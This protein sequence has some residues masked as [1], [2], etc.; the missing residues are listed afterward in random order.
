M[1]AVDLLWKKHERL[2]FWGKIATNTKRWEALQD[3]G[4]AP[5]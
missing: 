3:V 5:V 4:V 1:Q 2:I